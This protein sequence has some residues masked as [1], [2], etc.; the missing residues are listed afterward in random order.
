MA[1]GMN[2]WCRHVQYKSGTSPDMFKKFMKKMEGC[3]VQVTY[4]GKNQE[5]PSDVFTF[6]SREG[7]REDIFPCYQLSTPFHSA[8]RFT[9]PRCATL[10]C[11]PPGAHSALQRNLLY[12]LD[13]GTLGLT[14]AMLCDPT[15]PQPAEEAVE[16]KCLITPH[17]GKKIDHKGIKIEFFGSIAVADEKEDS[18]FTS[19]SK[20]FHSDG[21]SFSSPLELPFLFENPKLHE[22]YRGT[23][24][25]VVY[26]LRVTIIKKGSNVTHREEVWV[27]KTDPEKAA[28]MTKDNALKS[29]YFRER[30]FKGG[31]SMEVGVEDILHI[32]FKYDKKTYHMGERVLGQVSFRLVNVSLQRGEVSLVRRE[33]LGDAASGKQPLTHNKNLQ[34]YEMMDGTP[35][36]GTCSCLYH[37]LTLACE[38]VPIR[39]YLNSVRELTPTYENINNQFSV[40][41]FINLVLVTEDGKRYFKQQEIIIW[42]KPGP[43]QAATKA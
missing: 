28:S 21:G 40:K 17:Q 38:V 14:P 16:G 24:V 19:Q 4:D 18:T 33:T 41:Y 22:S 32:E 2:V 25:R 31:V 7:E 11:T 9:V 15:T 34:T 13:Q 36:K 39:I 26:V 5:N 37:H 42:R 10:P 43:D 27:S 8:V 35:I 1:R 30:E 29:H 23:N 3:E 6:E 20:M 12:M